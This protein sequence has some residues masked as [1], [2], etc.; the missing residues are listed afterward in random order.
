M[1]RFALCLSLLAGLA[2][3]VAAIPAEPVVIDLWPGKT[4]GDS[5]IKGQETQSDSPVAAG[6]SDEADHERDETDTHDLPAAQGERT[7]GRR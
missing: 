7:R 3:A 5:G 6:R 1:R 2:P 4:P